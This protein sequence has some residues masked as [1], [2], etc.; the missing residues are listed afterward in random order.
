MPKK[1]NTKRADGL[2]AVQVYIGKVDGKRK[3]KTAY[4]KTQKEAEKKAEEIK[5][6]LNAGIDLLSVDTFGFWC[7]RWLKS[8]EI[9]LT[10]ER[11]NN[12]RVKLALIRRYSPAFDTFE[13]KENDRTLGAYNIQKIRLFE[14]QAP[15]DNLAI[16][17]PST[18]KPTAKQTLSEYKRTV[19]AVFKYAMNNRVI[20]F[21][22]AEQL[23]ISKTAPKH[24]RRALGKEEQKRIVEFQHEAQLPAMLMMYAGLR[25][26]EVA[27]LLW[28][29]ID[30]INKAIT[31]NKSY[32]FKANKIKTPK[33]AAGVRIVPMPDVLCD[34]LKQQK[35]TDAIV[36]SRNGRPL[37]EN[38]WHNLLDK[39]LADMNASVTG[40]SKFSKN[41]VFVIELFTWHCLRHT[42]ASIL[43]DADVDVLTAQKLL[44]HSDIK[45]T[46]GIY[47][48]LSREKESHNIEKLNSFLSADNCVKHS[49]A[50]CK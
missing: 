33:T 30:F 35:K 10:E 48:H 23:T 22:P 40:C 20:E 41:R 47:T 46:L 43:Y 28:S 44:G 38:A 9:E 37:N 5:R 26:G 36:V 13:D 32:N 14:L 4:G 11:Y 49:K 17:N 42:Y 2:Y 12:Y 18:G 24:E 45:T 16:M 29:D 1:M 25:R 19:Q 27:A 34:F 50:A 6:Q 31:V 8:K 15:L 39:Y 7:D 3:Y 21:D